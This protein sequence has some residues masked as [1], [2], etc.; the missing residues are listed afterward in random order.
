MIFRQTDLIL[1]LACFFFNYVVLANLPNF[2]YF[3][4]LHLQN[5]NNN[6]STLSF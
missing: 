2:S 4:F 5:E 3:W 6:I 1:S